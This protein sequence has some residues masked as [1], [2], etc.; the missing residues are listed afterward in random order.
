MLE[1]MISVHD[2]NQFEIKLDYK[3]DTSKEKTVYNIETYIFLP[4]S[5]DIGKGN[6]KKEDFY[7]D[8]KS[9]IR[10][11]TPTV[12][13]KDIDTGADS[14]FGK[15][16]N[17]ITAMVKN[18]D[19]VT[20]E[21]YEYHIKMFSSILKS[22]LRDHVEYIKNTS[23]D[24]CCDH[25]IKQYLTCVKKLLVD[26]RELVH[27]LSVPTVESKKFAVYLFG[28]EYISHLVENYSYWLM[29]IIKDKGGNKVSLYGKELLEFVNTE[30]KYR[31][32]KRYPSVPGSSVENE[33]TLY[34]RSVFKKYM[35]S[36]LFLDI[37]TEKEGKLV[38]QIIFG[39][40][41]GISMIFATGAAFWT[42]MQYGG[43]LSTTFF[44]V[45][46]IS[47]MFKDRIKELL[48]QYFMGKIEHFFY[49]H[50]TSIY[51][52]PV[53]KIGVCRESFDF[54]NESKAPPAIMKLRNRDHITGIDNGWF[55]EQL[56]MYRKEITIYS[57]MFKNLHHSYNIEGINDIMRFN[58]WRFLFKM[59][60]PEKS[61]YLPDEKELYKKVYGERVY[62]INMIIKYSSNDQTT[63]E[64]YRIVLNR[65][66]LKR[67]EEVVTD[68]ETTAV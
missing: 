31:K 4:T 43:N 35:E 36:I 51:S 12:L 57:E 28:D 41:A 37:R 11:K 15:L 68:K 3:L 66:G 25:L 2:K 61:L 64:R 19:K 22:S 59:D 45:L 42:Q 55:G 8:L 17:A 14:P 20:I 67:I 53:N 9:Y 50:K 49:D 38:E 44:V 33:E 32:E 62:H 16:K 56:I 1:E 48:R 23:D 13:L 54:V 63:Y 39:I 27:E 58:V 10:F 60:N 65:N 29:R 7:S 34:R 30:H 24:D 26:Y 18:K 21:K 5:L 40:A 52:D 6:Y 47:Y 46:V